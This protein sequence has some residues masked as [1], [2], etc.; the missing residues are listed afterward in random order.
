[1]TD[2]AYSHHD[3]QAILSLARLAVQRALEGQRLA[4]PADC[5]PALLEPRGCFVT[6]RRGDRLRGCIGTFEANDPLADNLIAMA[7]ASACDP[8]FVDEPVTVDE[9]DQLSVEVSVL[10]PRQRIDDPAEYRLGIDGQY[11]VGKR[12]G[13]EV[14]GCFLPEVAV[15]Q[16]WD[17]P[18]TLSMLCAHKMGLDPDAWRPPTRLEFYRF[19]SIKVTDE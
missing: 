10:T 19:Q 12:F 15:D 17:L 9:L 8:R 4:R 5:P 18:T 14:G 2:H 13:S 16:Q 3:Q 7:R 11:I 1:M 6:L